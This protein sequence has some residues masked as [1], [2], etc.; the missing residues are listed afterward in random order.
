MVEQA[1]LYMDR[2]IDSAEVNSW[3]NKLKDRNVKIDF[4][5]FV[6]QYSALF[7]GHDPDVPVGEV[8]GGVSN[9]N[10][11]DKTSPRRRERDGAESLRR[12]KES[13][14]SGDDEDDRERRFR[15]DRKS[16]L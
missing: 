12:E 9:L 11:A 1:L 13:W 15:E 10:I 8:P 7:A 4:T 14:K 16:T 3:L 5:E 2:P 6:A